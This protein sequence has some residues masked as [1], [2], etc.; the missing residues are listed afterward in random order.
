MTLPPLR[1]CQRSHSTSSS[2]ASARG[3]LCVPVPLPRRVDA[4]HAV[5]ACAAAGGARHRCMPGGGKTRSEL[6]SRRVGG[7]LGA[8]V[9]IGEMVLRRLRGS[10]ESRA[11]RVRRFPP[12]TSPSPS[13]SHS[14]ARHRRRAA[15]PPRQT[16]GSSAR[17]RSCGRPAGRPPPTSSA[18]SF[19]SSRWPPA[20]RHGQGGP[21]ASAPASAPARLLCLLRAAPGGSGQLGTHGARPGRWGPSH[22][23]GCSSQP[24]PVRQFYYVWHGQPNASQA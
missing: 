24:P 13:R 2:V 22:C 10:S 18:T 14:L 17:Q 9:R 20:W 21:A 11:I 8:C 3:Q 12:Q 16:W 23:L 5:G 19:S 1:L 15:S 7:S 4:A 6:S